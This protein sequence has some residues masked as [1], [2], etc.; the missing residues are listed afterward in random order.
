MFTPAL[1]RD[2]ALSVLLPARNAAGTLR[3]ALDSLEA[4]SFTRW[5]AVVV[6]DGST[7]ETQAL[8]AARQARDG[9]FRVLTHPEPRGIVAALNAAI[10][11]SRAPLLARMDADDIALPERFERQLARMAEGDVVAV[12]CRVRFFPAEQVRDG[13]RRYEQ[14][15]NSL[16]TPVEHDRDLFVE[17]PLAH[18][19]MLLRRCAVAAAG[20]YRAN[21]WP[22][23]YDLLLRLWEQGGRM[24]KVPEVLLLW[25]EG[26]N[27]TSR[28]HPDYALPAF[29][30]CKAHYLARTVFASTGAA[31]GRPALIFGAGPVGKALARALEAEGVP[32]AGFVD[33][34]P[35]KIGQRI[36][37]LR[38]L[39]QRE[40]LA[41]RASAYGIAAV[42]QP[43]ARGVLREALRQA[44]W[45]ECTDFRCAA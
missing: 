22:E 1:R 9:R 44:G 28:N 13:A 42:G 45:H 2:P 33:L 43:G 40:G 32:L 5:E 31:A 7:D 26:E 25:R 14:W 11:V 37:G 34:D 15:L 27:R 29:T 12:G 6:D 24:A 19:S 20:G 39:S 17:C 38:V 41:R 23:D 35:R 18:P 4:Q 8:L 30:R 21:G 3:E 16:L 10:Q 36:Y